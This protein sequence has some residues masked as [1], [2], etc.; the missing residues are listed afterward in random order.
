MCNFW[1]KHSCV[2]FSEQCSRQSSSP[3]R[4]VQLEPR[5]SGRTPSGSGEHAPPGRPL[6][7]VIQADLSGRHFG[8]PREARGETTEGLQSWERKGVW[9]NLQVFSL[10][11]KGWSQSLE[12]SRV[13]SFESI[14]LRV[15]G[16]CGR[17]MRRS[18]SSPRAFKMGKLR[19]M[20]GTWE[21]QGKEHQTASPCTVPSSEIG[22]QTPQCSFN[23]S[24]CA[25]C[26][27]T[28]SRGFGV[29][30][31]LFVCFWSF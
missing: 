26:K 19:S 17:T 18:E 6:G 12:Q 24:N 23:S 28:Q 11:G 4:R 30:F 27:A 10:W 16:P 20:E 8:A 25:A 7:A 1:N 9:R 29:F 2:C 5:T 15:A 22:P 3:A 21:E 14:L 31:C 13:V